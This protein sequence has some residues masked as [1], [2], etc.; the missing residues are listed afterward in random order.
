MLAPFSY[1]GQS[2]IFYHKDC[3][4]GNDPILV[5]NWSKDPITQL[6]LESIECPACHKKWLLYPEEK[7]KL[8]DDTQIKECFNINYEKT[9]KDKILDFF[10]NEVYCVKRCGF[11]EGSYSECLKFKRL[12]QTYVHFDY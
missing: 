12:N 3:P 10:H 9:W 6:T 2:Q 7:M 1:T 8:D 11:Y 4:S 5:N